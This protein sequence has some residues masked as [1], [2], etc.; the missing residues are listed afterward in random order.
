M[1]GPFLAA[2]VGNR[3]SEES[4]VRKTSLGEARGLSTGLQQAVL[5][6]LGVSKRSR[7]CHRIDSF[8]R[9]ARLEV[10]EAVQVKGH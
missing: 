10:S 2:S 5:P 8:R 9:R 6:L 4:K 1:C 3:R 7:L